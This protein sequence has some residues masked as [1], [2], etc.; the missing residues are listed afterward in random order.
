MS[1]VPV[2]VA[3]AVFLV[4]VQTLT[5]AT[6]VVSAAQTSLALASAGSDGKPAQQES[7]EAA[8]A[9]DGT[10]TAFVS[11]AS[12]K[13]SA[14]VPQSA[15]G[16]GGAQ[17]RIYARNRLAGTTTLLSDGGRVAATSPAISAIGRLVA[18][19]TSDIVSDENQIDVVDR[20]ATGRGKFDTAGNLVRT[21]VTG[22]AGDP[23][24]QR[25][26]ACPLNNEARGLGR[27]GPALSADGSTLAYPA[28]LSPVSP[29]LL[30]SVS[31]GEGNVSAEANIVDFVSSDTMAFGGAEFGVLSETVSYVNISGSPIRWVGTPV[32]TAP[33]QIRENTCGGLVAPTLAVDQTCQINIQVD[34]TAA[35]PRAGVTDVLSGQLTTN[36]T[37]PDGQ[38]GLGLVAECSANGDETDEAANIPLVTTPSAVTTTTAGCAPVPTGLPLVAGPHVSPENTDNGNTDVVDSG[39]TQLGRPTLAWTTITGIGLLNF[40]APDCTVRLTDPAT[41]KPTGP[42]PPNGLPPCEQNQELGTEIGEDDIVP[43][44]C[45]AYVLIAPRQL[46]TTASL[47]TLENF[48]CFIDCVP[49]TNFYFTTT[50]VR[51]V[52]VA[53]HGP[54]FASAVGTVI[55]VNSAGVPLPNAA[56]PSLSTKGRFVAFTATQATGGAQVWRH[57]TD[58]AGNGTHRSGA[59]NLVSCRPGAGACQ[60]L[61]SPGFPSISGDG[62]RIAF[63]AEP[64][65]GAANQV[66]VRETVAARTLLVSSD[67]GAGAKASDG[68]A[69]NPVISQDG[70]TVAFS[71]VASDILNPPLGFQALNLYLANIGPGTVGVMAVTPDGGPVTGSTAIVLPSLDAHGRIV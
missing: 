34:A 15:A 22:N 6:P 18:Y 47:L 28:Q 71:S 45:N 49:F 8:L 50:G 3:L 32:A 57:D 67:R 7:G 25:V 23:R 31:D 63:L 37:N 46:A 19:E 17:L 16:E 20:L 42:P 69:L 29:G 12:L 41:A 55:S 68:Q 43:T 38:T 65:A 40:T 56:A 4:G 59:T 24:F 21:Q 27:C 13:V 14:S 64:S 11:A 58:A 54:R 1:R 53:K 66:Y 62:T 10:Q 48:E 51:N 36:A 35:C 39:P 61:T 5:S 9:A 52:V 70:S 60:A 44:S 26:T 2:V 30:V 33:F